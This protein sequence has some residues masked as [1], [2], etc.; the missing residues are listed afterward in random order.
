MTISPAE[1]GKCPPPDNRCPGGPGSSP[2]VTASVASVTGNTIAVNS[3]DPTG[4]TTH[5][6][7]TVINATTYNKHAVTNAQAI[8]NGKCMAAQGTKDG[9]V[10]HAATIDLE[11]CP[12][13]GR[14]HH[15]FH[16][17]MAAPSPPL[18]AERQTSVL[19]VPCHVKVAVSP[20]R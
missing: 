5:T 10:L 18:V 9:G 12:A 15:H 13:M 8:Q 20:Q 16:F 7:V 11:P 4:K 3:M 2:G 6:T 14:P 19:N 17:P 1:G